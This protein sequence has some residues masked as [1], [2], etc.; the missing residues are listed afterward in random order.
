MKQKITSIILILVVIEAI[1]YYNLKDD[2]ANLSSANG[3]AYL[4]SD[5]YMDEDS[6]YKYEVVEYVNNNGYSVELAVNSV[7]I[8][9][10]GSGSSKID[11]EELVENG[12]KISATFS[13]AKDS[14]RVDSIKVSPNDKIYVHIVSEYIGNKFP[15][16]EVKC[17]YSINVVET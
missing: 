5:T 15:K 11:D 8:T 10:I 13:K 17:N 2:E 14:K 7:S 6:K 4:D 9:C 16:N 3:V 12:F 1:A